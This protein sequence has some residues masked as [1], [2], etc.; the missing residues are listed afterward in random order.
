LGALLGIPFIYLSGTTTDAVTLI[1]FLTCFGLAKG[2]YDANIWASM[3]DVVHPSRRA[4]MLGLANMIGWLG[5]G[6]A[7]AA[8]GS[9]MTRLHWGLGQVLSTTAILYALVA[10]LLILAGAVYAP[11]DIRRAQEALLPEPE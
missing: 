6:L 8:T 4:T 3:Y 10:I 7:T 5:G 1:V 9:V 11:R 2:I